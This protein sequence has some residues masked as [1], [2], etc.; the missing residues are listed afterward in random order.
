M[1]PSDFGT[2]IKDARARLGLSLREFC[3]LADLDPGNWSKVERGIFP[4]PKSRQ[5]VADIATVLM[6][7]KGSDAW[8][9]LF[10]LAAVGHIPAGL[11]A[12]PKVGERISVFFRMNS[13]FISN[14]KM[15]I[16]ASGIS[17]NAIKAPAPRRKA[18]K[19]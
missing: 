11:L 6:I 17:L 14:A 12:E 3:R 5:C 2:F 8:N 1:S 10:E 18:E 4:P 7:E 9:R 13:D 16:M 19:K 15:P